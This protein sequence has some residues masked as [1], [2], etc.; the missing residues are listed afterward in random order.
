MRGRI[1]TIKPEAF[2]DEVLWGLEIETGLPLFRA[3]TGL[4]TQADREGRF[5]WRPMPLKAAILPYWDGDF[6][7]VL[8]ALATRGFVVRYE[9]GGRFY[10]H[11]RT[12]KKHQA[13]NGKEPPSDLPEPPKITERS[14]RVT[15]ACDTREP[16]A[17]GF[18]A[19]REGNG[20]ERK[21]TEDDAAVV[22]DLRDQLA[23]DPDDDSQTASPGIR[24]AD[25]WRTW[26]KVSDGMVHDFGSYVKA[27]AHYAEL[28]IQRSPEDPIAAVEVT[29]VWF[30][31]APTGPV[32]SGRVRNPTPKLL[33]MRGPNDFT[34][35]LDWW[36]ELTPEQKSGFDRY[37]PSRD[38]KPS[39]PQAQEPAP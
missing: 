9:S 36:S 14:E 7:R 5:E 22:L 16:R 12:F 28:A 21:G 29:L 37:R 18:P 25:V 24:A 32:K 34:Q 19:G 13:I 6:S 39:Q 11:V 8:D 38:G 31:H 33:L 1:R 2:L 4:F 23:P 20:R 10:G 27:F 30:W 17:P 26:A 15:D 3:F 35:S